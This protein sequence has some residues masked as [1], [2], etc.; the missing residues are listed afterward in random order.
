MHSYP[1]VGLVIHTD[2]GE[3]IEKMMH[4]ALRLARRTVPRSPG[5]EWFYTTPDAVREWYLAFIGTLQLLGG[6]KS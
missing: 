4:K 5:T 3:L 2:H 1:I 6:E